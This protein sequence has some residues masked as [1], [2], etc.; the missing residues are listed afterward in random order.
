MI[1]FGVYH[2]HGLGSSCEGS[3]AREIKRLSETLGG[4][5]NCLTLEYLRRGAY[6]RQVLKT[7]KGW[8]KTDI[9]FFLIGSSMGAYSWLDFLV[10]SP[11]VLENTNLKRVILITPPTTLFDDL[12]KWNPLYGKEKIFLHYG[13]GYIEDY[14]TF[15]ELLH[16]DIKH[17]NRRL[18]TLA[19][20]KV[21][22]VVAKNDTVV[23]NAPIYKLKEIAEFGVV[24]LNLC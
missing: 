20:P 24:F 23:D 18:L 1:R 8:I 12:Q 4:E 2:L 11:E 16:W 7:L 3:K 14:K 19:H 10:N 21:V 13:S 6:P 17:A 9:P 22:S 15:V 5:F